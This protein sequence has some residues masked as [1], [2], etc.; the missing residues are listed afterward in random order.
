MQAIL[1]PKKQALEENPR[2]DCAT[3]NGDRDPGRRDT[4]H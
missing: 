1:E 3:N 4:N 2:L